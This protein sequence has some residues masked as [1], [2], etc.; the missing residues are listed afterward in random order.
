[1]LELFRSDSRHPQLPETAAEPPDQTVDI[2]TSLV[3]AERKGIVRSLLAELSGKDRT[4]L[5]MVFLDEIDKNE[6]CA[7]M[8]VN[9]AYLRVLLHRARK[10]LQAILVKHNSTAQM[11]AG[12]SF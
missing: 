5:R 12:D 6:V 9:R 10:R 11:R 4:I 2:E 8:H 1:M 7:S 3:D